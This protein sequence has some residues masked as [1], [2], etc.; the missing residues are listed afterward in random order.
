ME[1][2]FFPDVPPAG[3]PFVLCYAPMDELWAAA[4]ATLWKAFMYPAPR[5][6]NLDSLSPEKRKEVRA[7]VER[8]KAT[9]FQREWEAYERWLRH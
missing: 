9:E 3:I 5:R 7:A 8:H 6:L 2:R 4:E 1:N